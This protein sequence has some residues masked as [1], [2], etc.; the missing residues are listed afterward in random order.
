MISIYLIAANTFRDILSQKIVY[1]VL[2]IGIGMMALVASQMYMMKMMFESGEIQDLPTQLVQIFLGI[3]YSAVVVLGLILGS[4]G[5]PSEIKSGTILAILS[6][7]VHSWQFLSGKLVGVLAF[8]VPVLTIGFALTFIVLS[9]Y[10]VSVSGLYPLAF[11]DH[12]IGIVVMTNLA[13]GLGALLSRAV[14]GSITMLLLIML[15]PKASDFM[16]SEFMWLRILGRITE[17]ITPASMPDDLIQ[18]SVAKVLLDPDYQLYFQVFAENLLYALTVFLL[19][20]C[21]FSRR[22]VVIHK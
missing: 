9:Y 5:V 4:G 13:L 7:P 15:A 11:I 22:Q 14:A 20:A 1:A 17:Y 8:L 10:N 12:A 2:I 18:A 3:W 16:S 6:R 21:L 19:A